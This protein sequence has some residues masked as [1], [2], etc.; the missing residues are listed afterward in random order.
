MTQKKTSSKQNNNK[1]LCIVAG[2]SGGHIIPAI[3]LGRRWKLSNKAGKI[4]FFGNKKKLDRKVLSKSFSDKT[5]KVTWLNLN[6]FP[7]KNIL[8]YP[9]FVLQIIKIFFKSLILIK[10]INPEKIISTGGHLSIPVCL[11]GKLLNKKIV[12]YELNFTPGKAVKFLSPIATEIF[13]TFDKTKK[14]IKNSKKTIY[15]VRFSRKD[16]DIEKKKIINLIN[17]KIKKVNLKFDQNKKTLFILGGSH[18]S[19]FLNKIIEKYISTSTAVPSSFDKSTIYSGQVI[20][21]TG[22]IDKANWEEFYSLN[23]IPAYTFSY[24][25]K[26]EN[27][28]LI[29]DLIISRGGAGALFEIKFFKK[30]SIIVPLKTKNSSHQVANS[31]AMQDKNPELFTVIDQDLISKDLI[32]FKNLINDHLF[33]NFSKQR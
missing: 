23:K 15:P 31:T 19:M 2:G 8:C 27:L 16:K 1:F 3:E 11:A 20:H 32:F 25:D 14:N 22:F 7:G 6:K 30:R 29:S 33:S 26:I 17:S 12:L 10:K 9:I 28:Y 4:I 21:Q 18:G 13:V 24:F 5:I